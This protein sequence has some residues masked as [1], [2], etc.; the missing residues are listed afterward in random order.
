MSQL[1]VKISIYEPKIKFAGL[2]NL[3]LN[4]IICKKAKL[5]LT[6]IQCRQKNSG[7]R[8]SLKYIFLGV[9]A[10]SSKLILVNFL[11]LLR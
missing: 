11:E 1:C 10:L 3:S 9:G 4:K 5:V 7:E 8:N 6:K 2:A